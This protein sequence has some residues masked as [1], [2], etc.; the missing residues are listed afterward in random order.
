MT[1]GIKKTTS[2]KT[3]DIGASSV[4]HRKKVRG[5]WRYRLS[6]PAGTLSVVD[7]PS[8]TFAEDGAPYDWTRSDARVRIPKGRV[9]KERAN[10]RTLVWVSY[11][12]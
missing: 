3:I 12:G 4:T 1:A 8:G 10:G 5:L 11:H 6:L 9:V 7:H 2:G